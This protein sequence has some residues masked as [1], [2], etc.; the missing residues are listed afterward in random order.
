MYIKL[1]AGSFPAYW[2]LPVSSAPNALHSCTK[3]WVELRWFKILAHPSSAIVSLRLTRKTQFKHRFFFIYSTVKWSYGK[4]KCK[5]SYCFHLTCS[6]KF[7]RFMS[8]LYL[9]KTKAA[10]LAVHMSLEDSKFVSLIIASSKQS[11]R[12]IHM[13]HSPSSAL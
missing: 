7:M 9:A 5:P 4:S 12:S 11:S 3:V 6:Y 8:N 2:S 10:L 1:H 13:R